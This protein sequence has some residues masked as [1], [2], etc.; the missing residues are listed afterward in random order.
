MRSSGFRSPQLWQIEAETE[1]QGSERKMLTPLVH[2]GSESE[3]FTKLKGH[4][5]MKWGGG[6]A[7]MSDIFFFL[8]VLLCQLPNKS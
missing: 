7:L 1:S 2:F 5:E 8:L 6:S 3:P 4:C